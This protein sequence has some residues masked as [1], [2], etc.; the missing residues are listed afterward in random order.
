M[1]DSRVL[2]LYPWAKGAASFPGGWIGVKGPWT[3]RTEEVKEQD[4]GQIK[5]DSRSMD[6][7]EPGILGDYARQ[8]GH[9]GEALS[10]EASG[11]KRRRLHAS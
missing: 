7:A 9:L 3:S 2:Q 10:E 11:R 4:E 5:K 8:R 1:A 6:W